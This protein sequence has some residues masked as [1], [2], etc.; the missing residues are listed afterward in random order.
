MARNEPPWTDG[1]AGLHCTGSADLQV[2][3][4]DD[5]AILPA[6]LLADERLTCR[7]AERIRLFVIDELG[8]IKQLAITMIVRGT[9]G[10]YVRHDPLGFA[11]FGLFA[12]G[13]TAIGDH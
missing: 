13:V 7:T 10:R 9:F 4:V 11:C 2:A 3:F 1:T 12:I 5:C 8:A 6:E